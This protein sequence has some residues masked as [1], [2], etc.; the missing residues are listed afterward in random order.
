MMSLTVLIV[1]DHDG[2]RS[3]VHCLLQLS[4]FVVVGEAATG[5]QAIKTVEQLR[6][7][8]VLLDVQLPDTDGLQVARRLTAQ[9]RAPIVVLTSS[10]DASDYGLHLRKCGAQGFIPKSELSGVSLR[11]ILSS[12]L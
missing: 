6:P 8:L 7:G 9:A 12:Y 2:F 1:D 11:A 10:R 3:R 4:G 5:A